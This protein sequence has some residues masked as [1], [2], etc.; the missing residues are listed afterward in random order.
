MNIKTPYNL[1]IAPYADNPFKLGE[2]VKK[3]DKKYQNLFILPKDFYFME[4]DKMTNF[5][6]L[7]LWDFFQRQIIMNEISK[8]ENIKLQNDP[9]SIDVVDKEL[10]RKL[11]IPFSIS[12][13]SKIET[14]LDET[15]DFQPFAL[16]V[17][18]RVGVGIFMK[19]DL[20]ICLAGNYPKKE[21]YGNHIF[22]IR[23]F[24]EKHSQ[25]QTGESG[26]SEG[27]IKDNYYPIEFIDKAYC[28][29]LLISE[30][31]AIFMNFN[32]AWQKASPPN[33]EDEGT[34][35]ANS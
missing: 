19:A 14:E 17:K 9:K 15:L 16:T 26:S 25:S 32:S 33:P 3:N 12:L 35:Y 20:F 7:F 34:E 13:K 27:A 29:K 31:K 24:L 30:T 5:A 23:A 1:V 18:A 6:A 11:F 28:Q 4:M 22:N 21:I 2:R 10:K 8:P